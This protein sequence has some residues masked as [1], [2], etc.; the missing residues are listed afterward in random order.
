MPLSER[1]ATK[2]TEAVRGPSHG[3]KA[4]DS[5]GRF[6]L[7]HPQAGF[8]R[9]RKWLKV[10]KKIEHRGAGSQSEV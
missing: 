2:K 8:G 3:E 7:K 4:R 9:P 6:H 1:S 10:L 5:A